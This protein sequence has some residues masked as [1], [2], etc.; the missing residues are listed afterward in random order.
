MGGLLLGGIIIGT[1]IVGNVTS[2]DRAGGH[3]GYAEWED[4]ASSRAGSNVGLGQGQEQ[5]QREKGK[6]ECTTLV[7]GTDGFHVFDNVWVKD[8]VICKHRDS[9][10][11]FYLPWFLFHRMP[12]SL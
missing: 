11:S 9:P 3:A 2:R 1:L 5:G 7:G 6:K 12:S 10:C 8:R 4:L